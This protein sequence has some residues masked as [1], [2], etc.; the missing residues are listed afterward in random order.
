MTREIDECKCSLCNKKYKI[1]NNI[2]KSNVE[3]PA[4][5]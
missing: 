5:Q 2:C 1:Q 4:S 3:M